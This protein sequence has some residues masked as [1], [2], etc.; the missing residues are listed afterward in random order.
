MSITS[1]KNKTHDKFDNN[2]EHTKDNKYYI[3]CLECVEK[4]RDL[5][6]YNYGFEGDLIKFFKVLV[7]EK[8]DI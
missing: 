7:E 5:L 3:I 4:I 8:K 2:N 6:T 1:S